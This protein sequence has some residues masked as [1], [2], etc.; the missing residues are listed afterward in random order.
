M[1]CMQCQLYPPSVQQQQQTNKCSDDPPGIPEN[2]WDRAWLRVKDS[3]FVFVTR[4]VLAVTV[5]F[6]ISGIWSTWK[7][8]GNLLLRYE[9]RT[10]KRLFK[11]T[12]VTLALY[13]SRLLCFRNWTLEVFLR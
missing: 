2:G 9:L 3:M 10:I 4:F 1:L 5:Y 7:R 13:Y 12:M 11:E 6:D 8:S